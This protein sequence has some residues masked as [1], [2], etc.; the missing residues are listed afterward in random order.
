MSD[1]MEYYR[2]STLEELWPLLE[3]NPGGRIVA[4]GTDLMVQM[5]SRVVRP[6]V[7][8]SLRAIGELS[9]VEAEGDAVRIGA[10]TTIA[11]I[12]GDRLLG[13]RYPVLVQAAR[14]LGSPQIRNAATV[15]GNLCNASPCA[16][17]APPL[18]V[19][20]AAARLLGPGG[21]R[22]VPL[23]VFFQGPGQTCPTENEI[24][25]ALILPAPAAGARG[26]FLKKRR[27]RMD[28]AL[29]SVAVQLTME[30]DTCVSARVAAGSVA[31][32]PLRLQ[33]VERALTG[34]AVTDDLLQRAGEVARQSVCPITDLR[35]TEEYRRQIIGVYVK[36]AVQR[37]AGGAA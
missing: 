34:A 33:E 9:G 1:R 12:A 11:Q 26:A 21:Q 28:L 36:R 19:L 37:A 2:P 22:E 30:G 3:A 29:A 31:P 7:M 25:S 17:T 6:G 32:V 8:L 14:C 18:L 35:T 24:L 13:E 23:A 20:E 5:A 4:G 10:T 27:V 15:G 16:D